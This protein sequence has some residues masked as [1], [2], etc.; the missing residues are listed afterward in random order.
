MC[1]RETPWNDWSVQ[2][3]SHELRASGGLVGRAPTADET[4]QGRDG[5]DGERE[6]RTTATATASQRFCPPEL[7]AAAAR[8]LGAFTRGF[9]AMPRARVAP[10]LVQPELRKGRRPPTR[11][12]FVDPMVIVALLIGLA[13]GALAVLLA[14]RPA[15]LER[16]R[17]TEEVIE[18]ER[19]L[20]G[21]EAELAVERGS[22][23]ERLE[24]AVK[25]L[26]AEALDANSARF[27]E[28]AETQPLGLRAPAHGLAAADGRPAPQRRAGPAR[29]LRRPADA[30][31]GAR[32][33]RRKPRRTRCAHRT[34]AGAGARRSCSN[35]VEHA[36]MLEHCDYVAQTTATTED[37][38]LRP[39]LVVRIPG[40]K[41]PRRR[42]EGA[43]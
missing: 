16:R 18:L 31:H 19:A 37:G 8:C 17:R 27:L 5:A 35:V 29:V 32:R 41:Q 7:V 23:D 13:V 40:G 11:L 39:D 6:H 10:A 25:A 4:E 34:S 1:R 14:V 15:L 38:A 33:A 36:G 42:R 24:T 30:G 2:P 43:L 3:G 21:A 26:S 9:W 12:P 20:A 22:L 28:L